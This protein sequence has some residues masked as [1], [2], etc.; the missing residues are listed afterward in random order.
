MLRWARERA[1]YS[2]EEVASRMKRDS[3][4]IHAW[5]E[6]EKHPTWRQFERLARDLY[7][8]P[9]ALFFFWELPEEDAPTADFRRLPESAFDDLEPDTWLA[10]RQAKARQLDLADLA[11]FDDPS[12]NQIIRD[13]GTDAR[14]DSVDALATQT[15]RYLGITPEDQF[16]WTSDD[17]ALDAWREAV[18]SVGVWVFKRSFQQRDVAGFCLDGD[19][20]PLVYLNNS[21]PKVRQM[22]TL[23]H[24]L[25][26]LLFGFNHLERS[27]IEHYIGSLA[28]HDREIEI[29]CNRFAGEFLVPTNHLLGIVGQSATQEPTDD[30][31]ATL[32]GSYRVS[33]EVVLR[34]YLDHGWIDNQFYGAKV[35]VWRA[36][37]SLDRDTESRGG[38]YYA[39][40]GTYLG[41][42][43]ATLAFKGYYQGSYDVDQLAEYLDIKASSV[44]GLE[45]WLS[46]RLSRQ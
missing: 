36:Q 37:R 32:S 14:P 41:T 5:E 31:L 17:Q 46:R 26:H 18:Q 12:A 10:I 3:A 15:R 6:G 44:D 39:T 13:L 28:G 23:F 20:N 35:D 38:N 29:A 4:E 19:Q 27:D 22:F 8:R 2:I 34:R 30:V 21:Q 45:S 42:K 1:G 7:H 25:A 33:R 11:E 24:E 43:Y 9:T 16:E 40:Q